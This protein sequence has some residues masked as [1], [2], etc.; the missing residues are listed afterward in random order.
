MGHVGPICMEMAVAQRCIA[1]EAALLARCSARV[2]TS[3]HVHVHVHVY[4][5]ALPT[6]LT[7]PFLANDL[8]A[9]LDVENFW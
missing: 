6:R 3:V 9:C 8:R 4:V 7:R 2:T 1:A 5:C